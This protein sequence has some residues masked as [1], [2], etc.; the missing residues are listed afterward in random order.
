MCVLGG[1]GG[2]KGLVEVRAG[3]GEEVGGEEEGV[4]CDK[5]RYKC[6]ILR[7]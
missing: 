3:R 1:G 7:I 6:S 5:C 4:G 2:G